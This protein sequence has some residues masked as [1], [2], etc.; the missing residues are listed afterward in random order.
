MRST[1]FIA[2]AYVTGRGDLPE[3]PSCV[4]AECVIVS[5]GPGQVDPLRERLPVGAPR[6]ELGTSGP[7]A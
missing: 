2:E 1:M 3:S 5:T 7:P 4:R 6:F